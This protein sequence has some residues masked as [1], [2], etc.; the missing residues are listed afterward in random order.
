VVVAVVIGVADVVDDVDEV[1]AF[2]LDEEDRG[3]R[4]GFLLVNFRT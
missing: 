3:I 2:A 4:G 1:D